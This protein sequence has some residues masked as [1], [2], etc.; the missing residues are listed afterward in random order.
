MKKGFTIVELLVVIVVIGIIA[1]ITIVAYGGIAKKA[2]IA[3]I[4]SDIDNSGRLV[5]MFQVENGTYPGSVTDCPTP[6]VG[7][8][9]LKS[10]PGNSYSYW[11]DNSGTGM[12][13]LTS[14]DSNGLNIS[15]NES[16]LKCPVNFIVVPGSATYNTSDFCVMKYEAKQDS[17]SIPISQPSGS[18]W[19]SI[20]Q[21]NA[22]TYSTKVDG[23]DS[24]H[25]IKEKEWLTIAQNIMSVASNWSSG[26]IGSGYLYTGHNDGTPANSL[27]SSNDDT[28]GYYGTGGASGQ[29]KR[30]LKLSNGEVIWDFAGNVWE[31]TSGQITG[32]QPGIIGGGYAWREWGALTTHGT[33][34]P[35]PYPSTTGITGAGTWTSANGIGV[36]YSDAENGV[37]HGMV[38]GGSWI[39]WTHAGPLA[40]DINQWPSWSGPAFGF[41]VAR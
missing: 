22:I 24:C 9:C 38:R 13:R 31:W 28:N 12:F 30:T 21:T 6:A 5:K 27:D 15:T 8:M 26:T 17:G 4:Q 10:S 40:L 34:N 2:K 23:C 14:T 32:G 7:N 18:P 33:L 37:L 29:Q 3:T 36:I 25:L 35:D 16:G 11:V 41:R 39:D 20:T 19:V 1:A